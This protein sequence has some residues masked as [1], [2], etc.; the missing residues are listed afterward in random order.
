MNEEN[1]PVRIY[2]HWSLVDN[3]EWSLGFGPHFGLYHIDLPKDQERRITKGEELYR[4]IIDLR[5]IPLL[6]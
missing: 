6:I 4:E 1:L 5:K 2:Y 3:F